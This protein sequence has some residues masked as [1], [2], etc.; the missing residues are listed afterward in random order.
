M[1]FIICVFIGILLYLIKILTHKTDRLTKKSTII[2]LCN[3]LEL[4]RHKFAAL[5]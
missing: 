2:C 4:A 5:E 3:L 1:I